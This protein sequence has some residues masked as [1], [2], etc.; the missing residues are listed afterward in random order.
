M[1]ASNVSH[2]L[3]EESSRAAF[4]MVRK[5]TRAAHW[6]SYLSESLRRYHYHFLRL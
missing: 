1:N 5:P 6:C 4:S 2:I 3:Q